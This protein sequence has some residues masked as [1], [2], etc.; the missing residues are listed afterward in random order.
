M[1]N[2]IKTNWKDREMSFSSDLT[3]ILKTKGNHPA[4]LFQK[5]VTY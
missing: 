5:V 2:L 3:P 4:K 1:L